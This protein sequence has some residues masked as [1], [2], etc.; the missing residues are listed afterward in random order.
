MQAAGEAAKNWPEQGMARI[1]TRASVSNEF[2]QAAQRAAQKPFP[3]QKP[4]MDYDSIGCDKLCEVQWKAYGQKLWPLAL[5]RETEI[6]QG[7]LA[8]LQHDRKSLSSVMQ[9]ANKHLTGTQYG[10]AAKSESNR[11]SIAQYHEGLLG[12][13][14]RL[15]DQTETAAKRASDIVNRGVERAFIELQR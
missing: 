10:G 4:K 2:D 15:I 8:T 7:R 9:E 5:A 11:V 3:V 14:E 12:E 6:L 1:K 13:V